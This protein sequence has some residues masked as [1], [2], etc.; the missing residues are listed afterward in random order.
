[1]QRLEDVEMQLTYGTVTWFDP[2]RGVGVIR[3]DGEG[4][5]V[6]VQSADIDGGGLQSLRAADSVAFTLLDEPE[7]RRAVNVWVP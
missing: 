2:Q 4:H 7:G 6:A 5:D 1:V 3:T